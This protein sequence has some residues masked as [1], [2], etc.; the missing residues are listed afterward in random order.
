MTAAGYR[1]ASRGLR[2]AEELALPIVTVID[3]PGAEMSVAAEEAGLSRA[4]AHLLADMSD[5]RVPTLAL[6]MGEGGSGGALALLPADRVLCARHA[7]LCPIAPEGASAILY[8]TT[9]RAPDLARTQAIGAADLLGFGLVDRVLDERPSADRERD[10][11]LHRTADVLEAEL[12]DLMAQ[13]QSSRLK[14]RELRYAHI[15]ELTQRGAA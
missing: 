2:I 10:A 7:S 9:E 11:F 14:A 6:L 15:G 8:R 4:I 13:E 3:T 5:V 1:K 12:R